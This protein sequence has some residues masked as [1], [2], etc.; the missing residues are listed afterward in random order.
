M[1]FISKKIIEK[2]SYNNS[3]FN[4]FPKYENG[5]FLI[6]LKEKIQDTNEISHD[7]CI[8]GNGKVILYDGRVK[9][10]KELEYND[11]VESEC[12]FSCINEIIT[13]NSQHIRKL[14]NINEMILTYKHPILV[15]YEWIY[16]K[17]ISDIYMDTIPLYNFVMKGNKNDKSKHT[18]VVNNIICATIG[19]C[20][21]IKNV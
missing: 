6:E 2:K 9:L 3:F 20:P 8:E 14:C 15:N 18:I 1:K 21:T 13:T 4:K 16:P 17:D 11:M 7:N 19:C 12:G 10:V 5:K